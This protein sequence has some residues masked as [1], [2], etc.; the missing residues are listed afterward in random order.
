MK[1]QRNRNQSLTV[2]L[3]EQEKNLIQS[4][5]QRKNMSVT[6]FLV[7]SV[8]EQS[9]AAVLKPLLAMLAVLKN[10]TEHLKERFDTAELRE[11]IDRQNDIIL[12]VKR[13]INRG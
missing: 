3:T 5:A 10:K 7:L 4:K 12:E 6:D 1:Y 2:R 8:T 9:N 13:L 11:I